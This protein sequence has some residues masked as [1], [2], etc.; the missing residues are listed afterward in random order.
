ME[1]ENLFQ[2][3]AAANASDFHLISGL[4]AFIRID[5]ELKQLDKTIFDGQA[6]E[7]MVK[8][9]IDENQFKKFTIEKELDFAY[10]TNDGFRFRVNLH[11]EKDNIGLSARTI[12]KEIPTMQDLSM[13]EIIYDLCNLDRGLILLTG[14]TGCGK[15]TSLASM[16][17][18]INQSRNLNIITLEDPIEFVFKSKKSIIRQRQLGSDMLSFQ[19]GLT[20]VL[21]QDPNVIMVGE[22]R[23]LETIAAT[24]T[25]AETG[26]LV[27]A[28]LHTYSA[29]QTIDRIIDIFPPHQQNQIRMQISITLQGVISQRL[30]PKKNHGRIAAREILINTPAV[31]NLVRENKIAQIKT[32]IQTSSREGMITMDNSLLALYKGGAISKETLDANLS[33]VDKK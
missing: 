3:T 30:I 2:K 8:K 27:F 4:P 22:M 7:A 1:L 24:I 15:S 26:H 5:G 33:I 11:F 28:T 32:V 31:A 18:Y 12:P 17:E 6:I 16:I 14:P 19:N 21:R 9:I 29:S 25:L 13:P 20:H 23:N 10:E